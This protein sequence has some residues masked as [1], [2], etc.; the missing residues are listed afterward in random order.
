M[1][2][3]LNHAVNDARIAELHRQAQR[4]RDAALATPRR[5]ALVEALLRGLRSRPALR[6]RAIPVADRPAAASG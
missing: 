1:H 4:R 6:P 2:P 5:S 3:S